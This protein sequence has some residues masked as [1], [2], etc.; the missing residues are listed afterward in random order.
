MV[1]EKVAP[2]VVALLSDEARARIN[3]QIIGARNNELYLFSKNRPEQI[4]HTADGWTAQDILDR[5]LPAFEPRF[6]PPTRSGQVF[7]WAPV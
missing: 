4:M 2:L 6:L 5:A 1:P 3:G 7:S